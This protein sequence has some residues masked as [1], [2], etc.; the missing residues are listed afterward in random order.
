MSATGTP[1]FVVS[2]CPLESVRARSSESVPGFAPRFG[3]PVPAF[4]DA[5]VS[6]TVLPVART[7]GGGVVAPF[8]GIAARA[9]SVLQKA[10]ARAESLT[11]HEV[12]VDLAT[13]LYLCRMDTIKRS[14]NYL[15]R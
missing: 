5:I 7:S 3:L 1:R 12:P 2:V 8:G 10:F 13:T 11:L 6:V 9:Y 14:Q 15:I 4:G